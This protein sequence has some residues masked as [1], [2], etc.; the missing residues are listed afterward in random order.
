MWKGEE[1]GGGGGGKTTFSIPGWLIGGY[2]RS[3]SPFVPESGAV[4]TDRDWKTGPGVFKSIDWK[5]K[6]SS[7][8]STLEEC[9]ACSHHWEA[10]AVPSAEVVKVEFVPECAGESS[11]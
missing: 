8:A 1:K 10:I 2:N 9:V 4:K 7:N 3:S 11:M 6:V 5:P